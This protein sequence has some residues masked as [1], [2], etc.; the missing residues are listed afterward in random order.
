MKKITVKI[1]K[2]RPAEYCTCCY[3]AWFQK[4]LHPPELRRLIIT[5]RDIKQNV[6]NF[7]GMRNRLC[8]Y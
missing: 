4:S 5:K 3:L 2:V 8:R 1:I 6:E 7:K